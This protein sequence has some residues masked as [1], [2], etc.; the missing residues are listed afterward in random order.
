MRRESREELRNQARRIAKHGYF[1]LLPDLYYRLGTI[2]FDIPRRNDA[3]SAVIRG[4]DAE[5]DQRRASWTTPAACSPCSTAR[6]R[7]S[8]ARSGCVGHCMS[9]PFALA[10]AA[11][12][13]RM[14]AAAALYGV[15]MVTDKP[16]SP[17][18]GGRRGQGRAVHRRSPRSIPRVPATRACPTLKSALENAGT[19]HVLETVPGHASRLSVRRARR[20]QRGR[21]R[22]HVGQA[23]R[24]VGPQPQVTAVEP[25]AT[26][27]SIPG[28][29]HPLRGARARLSGAAVRAGLLELAHRAL[30]HQSRQARACRRTGS[31]RSPSC[32]DDFRLIALDVRNAGES[33]ASVGDRRRLDE[34]HGRPSR[35]ARSSRRRAL[36]RHGRVHRR[37]VR[38]RARGG[39]AGAR[40]VARAA[41]SDR[42]VRRESRGA[43]PRVRQWA[44]KCA[45]GPA[46][47]PD[48]LPGFRQAHVRRRFH[49]QRDA[50]VRARAARFPMLLMPGDDLVH[51]DR[52]LGRARARA[53]RRDRE[54]V[55]GPGASRATRCERVREFLL[56]QH[57]GG[58]ADD[59]IAVLDD[60]QRVARA[61]ADWRRCCCAPT[62][63]FFER[64]VRRRGRSRARSSRRS[65]SCW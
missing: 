6:R 53:A 15:D 40:D 63:A 17:H 26:S 35:A 60:W 42:A 51:P 24:P 37:V 4:V 43:R 62:C 49:L 55:E 5:P 22:S 9:G 18:L 14:K 61:S 45:T 19:K 54:A 64:A 57:A 11:R 52:G 48:A 3:M 56:A 33:R 25:C 1:C 32:A 10:A 13:P 23:V 8:R 30:A 65:T 46:S 39:A 29:Q 21:R 38:A 59:K 20:L 41:E 36:S 7:S 50:R 34:L 2:R 28:G 44:A 47:M 12:F 27:A 58:N 31:I 16:D